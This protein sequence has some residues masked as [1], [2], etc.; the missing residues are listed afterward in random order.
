MMVKDGQPTEAFVKSAG[1]F[2]GFVDQLQKHHGRKPRPG[3]DEGTRRMRRMQSAAG[4]G[5]FEG[6]VENIWE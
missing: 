4:K 6:E 1:R 3:S 5:A 2:F